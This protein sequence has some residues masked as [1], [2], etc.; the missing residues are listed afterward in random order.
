MAMQP[1]KNLVAGTYTLTATYLNRKTGETA[2]IAVPPV[3]L[4][5]DPAAPPLPAPELDWVTQLRSLAAA[6]PQG[7]KG[8][9]L[10][11]DEIGRINQYDPMQDYVNQTRQAMEYRLQQE[12]KNRDFAYA[13]ALANVLKRRVGPAIAAMQKVAQLDSQNPS[14]YAYLAFVNLYDFRPGAAQAALNTALKLNPNLPELQALSGVA[15]LMR[16]NLAQAWQFAQAYRRVEE[17][18]NQNEG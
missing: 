14:A 18:R 15:S 12:P 16:G 10:A 2:A 3:S 5:I 11:F 1:P 17:R 9:N 8:L 7:I 13:L 6:L 4:R